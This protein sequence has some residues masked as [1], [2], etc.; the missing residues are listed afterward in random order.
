M[1]AARLA[2]IGG[3]GATG[4]GHM[5]RFLGAPFGPALA[6]AEGR[7]ADSVAAP[8]LSAA[9]LRSRPTPAEWAAPALKA[10]KPSVIAAADSAADGHVSVVGVEWTFP[11]NRIDWTFNPT[12]ASEDIPP[13]PEWTWQ[14]NR[15]SFWPALA[16]AYAETKDEKYARAF[17]RQF[18]DWLEQTGGLPPETGYNSA[19][20]P[21]RTIEEGLRLMGS[22]S[23]AFEVFRRS[24]SLPDDLLLAFARCG[25]AQARHLLAHRTGRNWLLIEMTGAIV[26]ALEFP[27]FPDAGEILDEALRVFCE[28]ASAQLLPDGFHNELSPD[29]HSVFYSTVS[30]VYRR[31][32]AAGVDGEWVD[33]LREL[34]RK[35]AEGYLSMMVPG[36]RMPNV[37]DTF[38]TSPS[39]VVGRAAAFFPERAD[40]AWAATEGREGAPPPGAVASRFLPWSGFA[41]MRT[42]W[43]RDALCV[44]FD[45]GPLGEGHWHQDK[46]S[47]S[48]W[49]GGE[50]LVFDDGG[51][52]YES[53][54][55][56]LHAISGHGHNTLL[57]DGLAE[58]RTGPRSASAPIDAGWTSTPQEDFAFGVYD[59][60]FGEEMKPLAKWRRELRLDKKAGRLLVDDCVDSSDGAL[61]DYTLLFQLDTTDVFVAPDGRALRAVYGPDR[62]WA[63]AMSFSEGA[64][65][66]LASGRMEPSP[67][68]WFFARD[69]GGKRIVH[70][71]TTVFVKA[72]PSLGFR[73]RTSLS[74]VPAR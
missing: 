3:A 74:A 44:V 67:A 31:A 58:N 37:N 11:S 66:E 19:G 62:K 16:A 46:L 52:H 15:M 21:W 54:P 41:V 57:V 10:G 5:A 68:G 69:T 2:V 8:A 30:T 40:F 36:F 17:A 13:N 22:W 27:E 48:L 59:Q 4:V 60:G 14:L 50:E 70:P 9:G 45:V 28:A 51:G 34:L 32:K 39:G 20:S 6:E 38:L 24:P 63:L 35:G 73:F 71:A 65:V 33:R 61:H 25:H 49:K 43:S 12:E 47:F 26:F 56:R 18:G 53:S 1:T 7:L 55:L 29:Y 23:M 72:G 42:G 64:S